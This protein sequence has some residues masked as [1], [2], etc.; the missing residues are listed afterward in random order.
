MSGSTIS[1]SFRYVPTITNNERGSG[2]KTPTPV[3]S[4]LHHEYGDEKVWQGSIGIAGLHTIFCNHN[5]HGINHGEIL[6]AR[7]SKL[8]WKYGESFEGMVG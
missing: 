4:L 2:V 3:I 6:H 8:Q 7:R 1:G 5:Y